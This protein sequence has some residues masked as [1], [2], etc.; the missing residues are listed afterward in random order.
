MFYLLLILARKVFLNEKI[1]KKLFKNEKYGKIL[2]AK[3]ISDYLGADYEEVLNNIKL[4]SEEIAFS[5]LTVN[6]TAD[7]IYYDDATYFN[8][9]LNFN[10][11]KS[12]NMQ[13]E[14]YVYQLYLGQL[15]TYKNYNKTKKIV[16][17]SIDGYD[18]FGK[19]EFIYKVRLMEE[20][21]KISYNDIIQIIHVNIDYLREI[22]YN[23]IMKGN[24]KLMLD[25]Y[26]LTCNNDKK[27]ELVY[28]E[29]EL[30]K[31]VIE[32]AKRVAGYEKMD[33]Y[34]SDEEMRKQDEEFFREEGYK[35]GIEKGIEQGKVEIAR[36]M[37]K[38]N[39]PIELISKY[40]NM[41]IDELNRLLK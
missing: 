7:V 1:A 28:R 36:N 5:S 3:V 11:T 6:S 41:S 9:E 40:T 39:V 33:L 23:E 34:I 10:S 26:F 27:L 14:S 15:H 35:L 19:N 20:K 8:I 29:D 30:M 22:D 38:E 2:S 13:L 37:Y 32:E 25:L 31:D 24:N 18:F 21:Y 12:K 16:Q 17:I 4:S